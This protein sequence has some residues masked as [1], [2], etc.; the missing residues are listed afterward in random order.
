MFFFNC[1]CLFVFYVSI[2]IYIYGFFW[3]HGSLIATDGTAVIEVWLLS[4]KGN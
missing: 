1:F 4:S 2:N 3:K